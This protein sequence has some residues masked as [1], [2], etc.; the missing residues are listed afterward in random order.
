MPDVVHEAV[1]DLVRAREAAADDLRR[2]RQ[3]LLS[4]LLRHG[5]IF[6]GGDHWTWRTGAGLPARASSIRRSRSCSRTRSRLSRTRLSGCAGWRSSWARSCPTGR[7]RPCRGL[8]GDARRLIPGR[9]DLRGRDRR[10]APLRYP[11]ATH[12]VP[13]PGSA[14]RSTGETVRRTGLTLAGNRRAR[15][16]LVEAAWASAIRLASARPCEFVSKRCRSR[17]AT[18]PGRPRSGCA[19]ATDGSTRRQEAAR[20]HRCD[21]PRDGCVPVGHRAERSHRHRRATLI[22]QSHERRATDLSPWNM[23]SSR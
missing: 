17:S 18:S 23:T 6:A 9:G 1:R 7:W 3:Q 22:F 12:V 14:E 21:R 15:R 13:R 16:V 11:A 2:K 19:P 4:F 8:S 10:S 5:R 20:H